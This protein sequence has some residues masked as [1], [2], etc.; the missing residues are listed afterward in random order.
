[1]RTMIYLSSNLRLLRNQ[2]KVSQQVLANSLHISRAS[3][4]KYEGGVHEPS[5]ELCV[6]IARYFKMTL[7]VLLTVNLS[8]DKYV[9]FLSGNLDD[10]K[11]IV[12]IQVDSKGEKVIEVVQHH[13]QAGYAGN[14]SDPGYIEALDQMALPFHEL[15]GNCRAFPIEGDSMPPF[16]TGSFVIGRR[17]ESL[18]E[19]KEGRRYIVVLRDE[20]IVFKRIRKA[21]TDTQYILT[22]DNPRHEPFGILKIDILEVWE[23]VAAISF[24]DSSDNY[25]RHEVVDRVSDLKKEVEKLAADLGAYVAYNQK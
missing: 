24:R 17:V 9:S 20:G 23:F 3:L 5:L 11:M 2:Q 19:V 8:D 13:A 22:S 18:G 12:P 10:S 15:H 1:M 25:F 4:A 6:R 14:Y 21:N 16:D 7:D